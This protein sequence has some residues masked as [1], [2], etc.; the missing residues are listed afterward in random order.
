M[1]KYLMS[2]E[3]SKQNQSIYFWISYNTQKEIK[4]NTI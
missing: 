2:F 4:L 3:L 1:A